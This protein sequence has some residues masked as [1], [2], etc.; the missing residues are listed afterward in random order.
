VHP[1]LPVNSIAE[2]AA[3]ARQNPRKL[4]SGTPGV[5]TY[6]RL[7]CEIIKAQAGVIS[8]TVYRGTGESTPD[9]LAGVAHI[10]VD[11]VTLPRRSLAVNGDPILPMYH[12]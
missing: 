5:D 1:S 4:S 2:L 10:K 11:P 12:C 9:F 8:S 6:C 3:Y 7:M